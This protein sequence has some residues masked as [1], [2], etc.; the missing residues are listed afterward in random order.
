MNLEIDV[1]YFFPH[2]QLLLVLRIRVPA[3][4]VHFLASVC[5]VIAVGRVYLASKIHGC[6]IALHSFI[7]AR[8]RYCRVVVLA[9]ENING[10]IRSAFIRFIGSFVRGVLES[11]RRNFR[12]S[13]LTVMAG[14][15]LEFMI[16]GNTITIQTLFRSSYHP[17]LH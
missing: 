17:A 3:I 14:I 9:F 1:M 15:S 4:S 10:K 8:E 5:T 12:R 2:G 11:P 13:A 7:S 16:V 6:N